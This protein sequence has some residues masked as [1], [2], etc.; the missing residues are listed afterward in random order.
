MAIMF[1]RRWRLIVQWRRQQSEAHA[2]RRSRGGSA[3]RTRAT[4]DGDI[5]ITTNLPRALPIL[6]EELAL[7]RAF[8][9]QEIECILFGE[10]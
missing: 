10:S 7:L 9:S 8:L 3:V 6:R 5:A 1:K 2:P 4:A